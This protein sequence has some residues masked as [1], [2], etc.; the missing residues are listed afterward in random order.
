MHVEPAVPFQIEL[1][2]SLVAYLSTLSF[3]KRSECVA[4]ALRHHFLLPASK[5][6][7]NGELQ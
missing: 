7:I 5:L 6:I 4:I 3:T 2:A 1:P